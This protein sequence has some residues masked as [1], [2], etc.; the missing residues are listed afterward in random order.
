M[1]QLRLKQEQNGMKSTLP[2]LWLHN[3]GRKVEVVPKAQSRFEGFEKMNY[4]KLIQLNTMEG[5]NRAFRI[6]LFSQATVR[7]Q[8]FN[9]WITQWASLARFFRVKSF[10]SSIYFLWEILVSCV[11]LVACIFTHTLQWNHDLKS[12]FW[13]W[14]LLLVTSENCIYFYRKYLFHTYTLLPTSLHTLENC[15]KIETWSHDFE[16]VNRGFSAIFLYIKVCVQQGVCNKYYPIFMSNV[17]DTTFDTTLYHN[18]SCDKLWYTGESWHKVM[19]KV[20][21]LALF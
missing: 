16:L 17:R 3:Y 9:K 7:I 15:I 4:L 19:S 12:R 21:S 11:H 20:V 18:S 14:K 13:A 5:R 2:L 8:T 10:L 6:K 1:I